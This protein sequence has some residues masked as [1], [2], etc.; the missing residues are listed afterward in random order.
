MHRFVVLELNSQEIIEWIHRRIAMG[1]LL[2][3]QLLGF[4]KPL[5]LTAPMLGGCTFGLVHALH[6]T[7]P[8]DLAGFHGGSLLL[9]LDQIVEFVSH[10][11]RMPAG[12]TAKHARP[13]KSRLVLCRAPMNAAITALDVQRRIPDGTTG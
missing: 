12:G 4:L 6:A 13:E 9:V 8:A 2:F 5:R 1:C 11:R 10:I 7:S 3:K